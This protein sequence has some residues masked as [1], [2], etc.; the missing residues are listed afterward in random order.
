MQRLTRSAV[1]NTSS[2]AKARMDH[3]TCNYLV[4]RYSTPLFTILTPIWLHC[5]HSHLQMPS[6]RAQDKGGIK[7][8]QVLTDETGSDQ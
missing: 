1:L 7:K 6:P 2:A 3:H 5:T 4:L 8:T